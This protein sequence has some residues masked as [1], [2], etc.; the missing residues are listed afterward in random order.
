MRFAS[1]A[2]TDKRFDNLWIPEP[3]SGC[4]LW[5]G[6]IYP[7]WGYGQFRLDGHRGRRV[8]AHRY[9]YERA[10]GLV[11]DGLQLDHLCRNPPCVNPLHLEIVTCAENIRR[12]PPLLV[13]ARGHARRPDVCKTCVRMGIREDAA[14]DAGGGEVD[15]RDSVSD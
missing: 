6:C 3:N 12:R 15:E 2:T 4:W 14:T 8:R 9:S 1:V 7:P 13:C 10:R 11:P 5:L